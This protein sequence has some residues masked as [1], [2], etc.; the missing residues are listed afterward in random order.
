MKNLGWLGSL[1]G[2]Q[3]AQRMIL[4]EISSEEMESMEYLEQAPVLSQCSQTVL[5]PFSIWQI[6]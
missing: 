1:S 2:I 6:N 3:S 4:G 5:S